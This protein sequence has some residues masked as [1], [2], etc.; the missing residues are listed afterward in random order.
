MS[1]I[2]KNVG[3]RYTLS[4]W[5]GNELRSE[6]WVAVEV[7][8]RIPGRAYIEI[9]S[10]YSEPICLVDYRENLVVVCRLGG[11]GIRAI[12]DQRYEVFLQKVREYW[13]SVRKAG[14][15]NRNPRPE[16]ADLLTFQT[17]TREAV[18]WKEGDL[19]RFANDPCVWDI[20]AI[21]A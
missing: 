9:R 8:E 20:P 15:D 17:M 13:E 1:E 4:G 12:W 7:G 5:K 19:P 2:E 11:C 10:G 14:L 16:L 6:D 18:G 3:R 21:F